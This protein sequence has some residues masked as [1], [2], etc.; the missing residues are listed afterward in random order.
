MADR[1]SRYAIRHT[2]FTIRALHF[3]DHYDQVPTIAADFLA[4]FDFEED[5]F[6]TA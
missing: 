3:R 2:R 6:L 4:V 5:G 1:Y